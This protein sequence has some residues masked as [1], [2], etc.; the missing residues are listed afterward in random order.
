MHKQC[1]L[2]ARAST[3]APIR[4]STMLS[5]E[6]KQE[7]PIKS[8][9]I[10]VFCATPSESIFRQFSSVASSIKLTACTKCGKNVDPYVE[11]EWLLVAL[12]CILLRLPAYRHVLFHRLDASTLSSRRMV[13]TLLASSILHSYV[14]WEA[15]RTRHQDVS[16]EKLMLSSMVDLLVFWACGCLV[17]RGDFRHAF[18]GVTFP[19]AFQVVTV[20][21]LVWENT[22]TVR[23]LGSLFVLVFQATAMFVVVEQYWWLAVAVVLRAIIG[24]LL[25]LAMG[26]PSQPCAGLEWTVGGI[27]FCVV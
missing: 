19:T 9:F 13:Q 16:F 4:I 8:S 26:L 5:S 20:L 6:T 17:A 7:K 10:C 23:L 22:S 14:K 3:L 12:D 18:L 11:R 24:Q 15:C 2:I 21:V 1:D 27:P 25:A